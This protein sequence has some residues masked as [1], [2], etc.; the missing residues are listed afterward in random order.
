VRFRSGAVATF[1][2]TCVLGA[3]AAAGL[4]VL[5]PGLRL[6]LTETWLGVDEGR[7]ER[8]VEPVDDPRVLV[9]RA[10]IGAVRGE[11]TGVVVSYPEALRTHRL[12]CAIDRSA[13]SR[14]PVRVAP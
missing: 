8:R 6:R 12:A 13:R 11:P 10:F 2:A 4:D 1:A 5:A 7:G 14:A 3:K 9:D